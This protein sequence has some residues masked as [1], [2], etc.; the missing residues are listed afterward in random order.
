MQTSKLLLAASLVILSGCGGG[1]GTTTA[2]ALD[3]SASMRTGQMVNPSAYIPAQ[4]Y[5]KTQD[6][7]GRTHNPC[8]A[9]HISSQEPNYVNDAEQ[10]LSYGFPSPAL[11]N[12]WSNLFADHSARIAQIDDAAILSYVRQDNYRDADGSILLARQLKNLPQAS[13]STRKVS[14]MTSAGLTPAGVRLPTTRFWA[15]SG[16]QMA[17]PTMSCS[18]CPRRF[19]RRKRVNST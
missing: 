4:C 16:P 12:H 13:V 2:S 17:P 7:L 5:T 14:I 10:Q 19:S 18:A 6:A 1:T 9:C 15:R 11:Q 3:P 8:F